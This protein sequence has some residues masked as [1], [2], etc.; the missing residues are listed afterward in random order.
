VREKAGSVCC[1]LRSFTELLARQD[2]LTSSRPES[3]LIPLRALHY[4]QRRV[5][6]RVSHPLVRGWGEG[7]ATDPGD[8]LN[9]GPAG[10]PM[11]HSIR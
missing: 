10:C 5:E 9:R 2:Y 11:Y 4:G 7:P 6:V 8:Y 3:D 1:V